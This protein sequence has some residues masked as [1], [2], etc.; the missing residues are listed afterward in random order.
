MEGQKNSQKPFNSRPPYQNSNTLYSYQANQPPY[1]YKPHQPDNQPRENFIKKE[2]VLQQ[3]SSALQKKKFTCHSYQLGECKKGDSCDYFH[4]ER[5]A[6]ACIDPECR[7]CDR[8]GELKYFNKER[9]PQYFQEINQRI[10]LAKAALEGQLKILNQC[11]YELQDLLN[12][13]S[14]TKEAMV[15][16]VKQLLKQRDDFINV[17]NQKIAKFLAKPDDKHNLVSVEIEAKLFERCLPAYSICQRVKFE[18]YQENKRFYLVLG[19]TGS[20]K[21]TQ[22]PQFLYQEVRYTTKKILCIQPRKIAAVSLAERVAEELGVKL[23]EE[24]GFQVGPGKKCKEGVKLEEG[25][26]TESKFSNNTKILFMTENMLLKRLIVACKNPQKMKK[27]LQ[28]VK[29]ILLDEVHERSLWSDLIFGILKSPKF[30]KEI[31]IFLASATINEDLFQKY[32]DDCPKIKIPGRTFPVQIKYKPMFEDNYIQGTVEVLKEIVKQKRSGNTDY[33]G[34]VLVFLT[35]FEEMEDVRKRINAA[36]SKEQFDK[37]YV[38]QYLHGKLDSN[39][40]QNVFKTS[41]RKNKIILA[42]KIAESSIT[43]DGVR[44]VI[45]SGY[46][47]DTHYDFQKGIS[48]LE[49]DW[50]S[51]ASAQQR[52]GRAGRTAPGI[53]FR[54]YSEDTFQRFEPHKKPQIFKKNLEAAFLKIMDFG[55]D[56]QDFSFLESPEQEAIDRTMATLRLLEALDSQNRLTAMGKVM[57]EMMSTEPRETKAIITASQL[58]CL[59]EILQVLSMEFYASSLFSRNKKER[60]KAFSGF[61]EYHSDHLDYLHIFQSWKKTIYQ[62]RR[63]WCEERFIKGK[64]MEKV[65]K[66]CDNVHKEIYKITKKNPEIAY[67]LQG[68]PEKNNIEENVLKSLLAASISSLAK[69][70]GIEQNGY[71]NVLDGTL[72]QIHNFSGQS[73]YFPQVADMEKEFVIYSKMENLYGQ[74]QAKVVS[75]VKSDWLQDPLLLSKEMLDRVFAGA[76][77]NYQF[78]RKE[79]KLPPW[80]IKL[81]K[82]LFKNRISE[83]IENNRGNNNRQSIQIQENNTTIYFVYSKDLS[84]QVENLCTTLQEELNENIF[85]ENIIYNMENTNYT[86]IITEGLGVSEILFAGEFITLSYQVNGKRNKSQMLGLLGL[87]ETDLQY[88]IAN[89]NQ[90]KTEGSIRFK[91]KQDAGRFYENFKRKEEFQLKPVFPYN[92]KVQ[93]FG[94]C[95]IKVTFCLAQSLGR[96]HIVFENAEDVREVMERLKRDSRV[97]KVNVRTQHDPKNPYAFYIDG[98]SPETDEFILKNH[99]MG[100][101]G[102]LPK[103]LVFRKQIEE[104]TLKQ[105]LEEETI[106][107]FTSIFTQHLSQEEI[108]NMHFSFKNSNKNQGLIHATITMPSKAIARQIMEKYNDTMGYFGTQRMRIKVKDGLTLKIHKNIFHVMSPMIMTKIEELKSAHPQINIH[109]IPPKGNSQDYKVKISGS[110]SSINRAVASKI[111]AFTRGEHFPIS[112]QEEKMALFSSI[113]LEQ[114]PK[115]Q[116]SFNKNRPNSCYICPDQQSQKLIIHSPFP[117]VREE[118]KKTIQKEL[119]KLVTIETIDLRNYKI[120]EV[121]AEIVKMKSSLNLQ[122]NSQFDLTLDCGTKKVFVKAD[123]NFFEAFQKN[124]ERFM[125]PE[126]NQTS[127]LCPICFESLPKDHCIL[128][129]C[130]HKF[131]REDLKGYLESQ[132]SKTH[133]ECPLSDCQKILTLMDIQNVLSEDTINSII[134]GHVLSFIRTQYNLYR[135][136]PTVDC[137][138]L[139]KVGEKAYNCQGCF[140]SSCLL[141]LNNIHQAHPGFSCAQFK[142]TH[143][144]DKEFK[145][146]INEGKIKMAKCCNIPLVKDQG[147]NHILCSQCNKHLCYKCLEVFSSSSATYQHLRTVHGG[148]H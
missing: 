79:I 31:K 83:W 106:P 146:L 69:F 57:L 116:E 19:E 66:M 61:K 111:E 143:D 98:L 47:K 96:A 36:F 110:D 8:K 115:I 71:V 22:V 129:K 138:H 67:L 17:V 133:L 2:F 131:C 68:T 82:K 15:A 123:K 12:T 39:E 16:K 14:D 102:G 3:N 76:R 65:D 32:F 1:A 40:Q 105:M 141:D 26:Y 130:G 124:I 62:E 77:E 125:V 134:D 6:G 38:I 74:N 29:A 139:F 43:I 64:I 94:N 112:S 100:T 35:C 70:S 109:L 18:L 103:I 45:D 119:N 75:F 145:A 37:E 27:F 118:A 73:N 136:C 7:L 93:M 78:E 23:G 86:P 80:S 48:V 52:M 117:Q 121:E 56:P 91:K 104:K 95:K 59:N 42:T 10:S 89:E 135:N 72:F 63:H 30:P 122:H 137:C 128:Y 84:K 49:P 88:L 13:E 60:E 92:K 101:F 132:E 140:E 126:Q 53:C 20:G 97:D 99:V 107:I 114:Y 113:M 41:G 44:I 5:P 11:K 127:E 50:I 28:S 148:L 81:F 87:S 4:P 144:V 21:T 147:C 55:L 58:G 90:Q 24:V 33:Q 34:H 46:D 51:Q 25:E 120:K 9:C 54:L 142:S 85:N 108:Q